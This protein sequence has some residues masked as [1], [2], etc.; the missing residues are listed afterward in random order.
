M[1]F[2]VILVLHWCTWDQAPSV[3]HSPG[4]SVGRTFSCTLCRV[5]TRC[6]VNVHFCSVSHHYLAIHLSD[7]ENLEVRLWQH[8]CSCGLAHM[9]Q[10]QPPSFLPLPSVLQILHLCMLDLFL[11]E[12]GTSILRCLCGAGCGQNTELSGSYFDEYILAQAVQ[13]DLLPGH[14]LVSHMGHVL[15]EIVTMTWFLALKI[16]FSF[17]FLFSFSG[18]WPLLMIHLNA[19]YGFGSDWW[20][21]ETWYSYLSLA[22]QSYLNCLLAVSWAI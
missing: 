6:L 9:T 8:Y 2:P 5:Q 7:P 17:T 4:F 12:M 10:E 15:I 18:G 3:I 19:A 1:C 13:W 21:Y 14:I 20:C 22:K 16:F 11:L